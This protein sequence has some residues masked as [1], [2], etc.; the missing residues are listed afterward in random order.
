MVRGVSA[1]MAAL[2]PLL[3]WAGCR[4]QGDAPRAAEPTPRQAPAGPDTSRGQVEDQALPRAERLEVPDGF[5]VEVVARDLPNARMM[6]LSPDGRLF[7]TQTGQGRVTVVPIGEGTPTAWATGRNRPHGIAFHNGYLYVADTD[8]VVRW[9]YQPGSSKAPGAPERLAS[10]PG[11]AG[12]NTRTL[13]V[14]PDGKLYVSVGSS[15]NSCIEEH[16]HRAA[17]LQMN[18]DGSN[19]RVYASGLRN[20]VGIT[21][22][23]QGRLWATE[24]GT[25]QMGDDF[26]PEELNLIREGAFYGWPFAHANRVPDSRYGARY[27]ER[28]AESR[29]PSFTFTAHSAPLGLA[30]YDGEQFPAEY[31]GDLFV[32]LHG[33]WNRSTPSGY[34]VVRVHFENGVPRRSTDFVTGFGLG[35]SAWA[36]P[37]GLLVHSDGSLLLT[38]DKGGNL[39]RIRWVGGEA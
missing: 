35:R 8:A 39:F 25:D 9:R 26:P 20:A 7:V 10:L 22:D 36:R 19:L 13:A 29:P 16:P 24:N 3:A 37:V 34:K 2:L 17:I 28:V 23:R 21:F 33:S 1:W 27:R 38:D 18:P 5:R 30:F 31:R 6:A 11:G 32:A 12:H 15:C 14:G 4:D